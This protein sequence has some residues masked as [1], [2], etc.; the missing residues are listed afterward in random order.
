MLPTQSKPS[1][2]HGV[3]HISKGEL[4]LRR[5]PGQAVGQVWGVYLNPTRDTLAP[6]NA[7][8]LHQ[9]CLVA[10]TNKLYKLQIMT[11]LSGAGQP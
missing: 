5:Q 9:V 3:I 10:C 8:S 11:V 6:M 1:E 7:H 2:L 4:F